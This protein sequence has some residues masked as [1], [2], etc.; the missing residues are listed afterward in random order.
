MSG[1]GW[2]R[3]LK[4]LFRQ[5]G[6]LPLARRLWR[7]IRWLSDK[8]FRLDERQQ[9][10]EFALFSQ[11]QGH[12]FRHRPSSGVADAPAILVVNTGRQA[13][14]VELALV[15]ACE[16]A[17][18]RAAVLADY[19]P[20][21]ERYYRYCGVQPV[22][23]WEDF[24]ES[25]E[26]DAAA[27]LLDSVTTFEQF[28]GLEHQ[29][30]RVGKYAASTAL[31]QLRVGRLD[32]SSTSTKQALLPFLGHAI[33]CAQA[34]KRVVDQLKPALALTI[35]VGYSPRG[36]LYDQCLA[37]GIDTITWNAAH[38][39][40][41]LM[42]KRYNR[43]NRDVHP[44]S[45]S[46]ATW[47]KVQA[48]P[49]GVSER[50]SLREEIVGSYLKGEWYSEVG[51]QFHTQ[52]QD[53]GEV[54]SRLSLHS[55][56]KTAVIFPHI[57]WDGTFFWGTDLFSSY[58]EWFRETMRAACA[59]TAVNWIVKVHPANMVK[60]MR[61][62]IHAV[63]LEMSALAS[64]GN[65]LPDHIQVIHPE[66]P[67]STLSLYSVM[68]YCVT[69]RGTV[70][71]EAA[72]FGIPVLTA[73]TGRYDR[74]GFTVDSESIE[75]YQQRLAHI[76]DIP[77]LS[78]TQRELAERFAHGIFVRRPLHLRSVTLEYQRDSKA[79]L[80]TRICLNKGEDLGSASDLR[81][82]SRW[83]QSGQEDFL[84]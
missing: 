17:G 20:W 46:G 76:Q 29:G 70:G 44:A 67:M 74:L 3:P 81:A 80:Q 84:V 18:F 77:P 27:S 56:K 45:L 10:R 24:L 61:D 64:L 47:E 60:N 82:F 59:N 55:A 73:G 72:S 26:A 12:L 43:V 83:I 19:D 35:D 6:L 32:L 66:S 4:R 78:A 25:S 8:R 1:N 22:H 28:I 38:K 39:N 53:P 9:K 54:R 42:L 69:V 62:G 71:I 2:K 75:E 33:Q 14:L 57:F 15:K 58:E 65:G 48:M 41:T 51:T 37:A 23:F 36:E 52:L 5:G 63:P 49:W 40:N 68:D 34:S 50:E 79:S 30:V 16:L 7:S 21:T 13:L 31:R 11:G